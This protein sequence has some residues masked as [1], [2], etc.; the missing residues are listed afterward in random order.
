LDIFSTCVSVH[1]PFVSS[2]TGV[3]LDLVFTADAAFLSLFDL[4]LVMPFINQ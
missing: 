4:D 2:E 3:D 1:C